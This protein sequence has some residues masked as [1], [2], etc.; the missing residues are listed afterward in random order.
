MTGLALFPVELHLTELAMVLFV[1]M[2]PVQ[3]QAL[4]Q[5]VSLW[6]VEPPWRPWRLFA[7]GSSGFPVWFLLACGNTS[8]TGAPLSFLPVPFSLL[9]L[10]D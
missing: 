6:S 10:Y 1:L 9:I 2:S 7:L 8:V 5:M 4:R 3:P